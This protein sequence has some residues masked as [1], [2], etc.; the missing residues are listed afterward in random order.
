MYWDFYKQRAGAAREGRSHFLNDQ[1]DLGHLAGC[2]TVVAVATHHTALQRSCCIIYGKFPFGVLMSS[3]FPLLGISAVYVLKM[4][5]LWSSKLIILNFYFFVLIRET[6][7][8]AEELLGMV[9][10][11]SRG[12]AQDFAG[13]CA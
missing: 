3:A 8:T 4:A 13:Q 12:L 5:Q 6:Q 10:N 1:P 9:L 7:Y 2:V 11:Y